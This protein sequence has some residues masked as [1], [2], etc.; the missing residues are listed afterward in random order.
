M[1]PLNIF[2]MK[3]IWIG[4]TSFLLNK[5]LVNVWPSIHIAVINKTIK[6]PIKISKLKLKKIN[7]PWVIA[8]IRPIKRTKE[9]M[10]W[11][12]ETFSFSK[13][14]PYSRPKNTEVFWVKEPFIAPANLYPTKN[15]SWFIPNIMPIKS[16]SQKFFRTLRIRVF[17]VI[18]LVS[19]FC[20]FLFIRF[21]KSIIG[22]KIK[23]SIRQTME[24]K[25]CGSID[26][27]E[28]A[29]IG[30]SPTRKV[31]ITPKIKPFFRLLLKLSKK[32]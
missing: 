19:V 15:K 23:D 30:W 14:Y 28:F 5:G 20:F 13:I 26:L 17:S 24:L 22:R 29:T 3:T 11:I 12:L 2:R 9:N 21:S 31:P 32:N 27:A 18:D 4:V 7:E 1:E 6:T 25:A 10:S 16:N 8:I